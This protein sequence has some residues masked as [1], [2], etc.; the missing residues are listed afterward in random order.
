[1]QALIV[2]CNRDTWQFRLQCKSIGKYL[3]PCDV[4]I[5][6][7]EPDP[8]GWINW[9]NSDCL[10]YL[11]N[12]R[13]QVYTHKDFYSDFLFHNIY[14]VHGWVSQQIFKLTFSLKTDQPYIVLD[15]KNW[16]V[17]PTR[18]QDIPNRPR[19]ATPSA[20][21][22]RFYFEARKKLQIEHMYR[23]REIITPY[24]I[25]P[26]VVKA[27]LAE[28]G[29]VDQFI[30]WFMLYD[31]ASEFMLYDLY[32]QHHKLDEDTGSTTPYSMSYS[33][34]FWYYD[35]SID[36]DKFARVLSDPAVHLI[37]IQFALIE[38]VNTDEIEAL[39]NIG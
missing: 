8:S 14:S 21:F 22:L 4:H 24:Y 27:I 37:G 7:N 12:H 36:L 20:G 5:V 33:M 1:M 13:V 19:V 31:M 16:F 29:G 11:G 3:E 35:K 26:A 18:L 38:T 28:F 10:P 34:N 6:I 2:T 15:S 17:K 30:E 39:L 32:A 25:D 23:I 9:F